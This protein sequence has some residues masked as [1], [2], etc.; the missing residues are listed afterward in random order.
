VLPV[1]VDGEAA[2]QDSL[3]NTYVVGGVVP[4]VEISYTAV[5][6]DPSFSTVTPLPDTNSGHFA[7]GAAVSGSNLYAIGGQDFAI[8]PARSTVEILNFT[9]SAQWGT[10]SSLNVARTSFATVTDGAGAIYVIGGLDGSGKTLGSVEVLTPGA[11]SWTL[12]P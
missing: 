4:G 8:A 6:I 12:T 2:A 5:V 9:S 1:A 7:G 3:G 11:T 10:G